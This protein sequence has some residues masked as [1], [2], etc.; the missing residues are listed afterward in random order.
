MILPELT[1]PA[2]ASALTLPVDS[3][4]LLPSVF[5]NDCAGIKTTD[6]LSCE[7]ATAWCCRYRRIGPVI[8][9]YTRDREPLLA[10]VDPRRE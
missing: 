1:W 6:L 4:V 8:T 2:H 7:L 3:P 9:R 5:I 10:A